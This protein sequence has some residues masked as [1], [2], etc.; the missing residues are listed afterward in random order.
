LL[1]VALLASI[2]HAL[3]HAYDHA[4]EGASLAHWLLDFGP[5]ALAAVLLALVLLPRRRPGGAQASHRLLAAG[6]VS[7]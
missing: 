1:A 3:N 2:L 5:L 4:L 6:A 7:A